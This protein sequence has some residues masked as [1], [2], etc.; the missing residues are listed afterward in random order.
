MNKVIILP[1]AFAVA[2]LCPALCFAQS[3]ASR[4]AA[5]TAVV[6][7]RS[8]SSG[9]EA[10]DAGRYD[11]ALDDFLRA[12]AS[13]PEDPEAAF[14][15]GATYEKLGRALEA[16]A[17]YALALDLRPSYARARTRL[18]ATLVTTEQYREAIDACHHAVGLSSIDPDLYY[19]YGRAFSGA[20]LDDQ[21]AE[22]YK[23]AIRLRPDDA[24]YHLALGLAYR[25]LGEYREAL[26]SL[27]R[28]V[29]LGG[30]SAAA[31]QAYE[32][33]SSEVSNLE[34]DLKAVGG[35]ERVLNL[36]HAYRRMGLYRRAV[37]VYSS[38][39][40]E[41]PKDARPLYFEGLAYYG[42]NQYYRALDSYRRALMIDPKM[43]EARRS[44]EWLSAY[45]SG[46]ERGDRLRLS[47]SAVGAAQRLAV[48]EKRIVAAA[49][50]K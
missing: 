1:L 43:A 27:E 32:D 24:E 30:G 40:S 21:A 22:A 11:E 9:V 34:R 25:R 48:E 45:V 7:S 49:Q 23:S 14:D 37:A 5:A 42:L 50:P 12:V 17:A 46:G 15:A 36:G 8:F 26:D 2:A 3:A 16:S 6:Y 41:R 18:C 10:F 4:K 19:Q 33:V 31:K 38:A 39:A 28:A 13:N 35:Y 47:A 29:R 44:A 20:G